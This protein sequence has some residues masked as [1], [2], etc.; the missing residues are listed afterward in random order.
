MGEYI[1]RN[2]DFPLQE[3]KYQYLMS[4]TVKAGGPAWPPAGLTSWQYCRMPSLV[5]M[6][7]LVPDGSDSHFPFCTFMCMFSLPQNMATWGSASRPAL[8]SV[9]TWKKSSGLVMAIHS[10]GGERSGNAGL[11]NQSKN[12]SIL[13][14]SPL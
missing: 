13:A 5:P 11:G 6:Q 2:K 10:S 14:N 8:P 7:V 9:G 1:I 12:S 4:K 3:L